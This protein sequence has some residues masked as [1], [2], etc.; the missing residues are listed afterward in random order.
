MFNYT[1]KH[2][3]KCKEKL[4]KIASDSNFNSFNRIAKKKAV[5]MLNA[6]KT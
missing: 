3:I 1:T 6:N 5:T 2:E 4:L